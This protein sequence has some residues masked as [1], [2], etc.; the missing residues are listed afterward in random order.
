VPPL[1]VGAV[2]GRG[3]AMGRNASAV[4]ISACFWSILTTVPWTRGVGVQVPRCAVLVCLA[5]VSGE[6]P[7]QPLMSRIRAR[8]TSSTETRRERA[9][10]CPPCP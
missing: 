6:A 2:E 3:A 8:L 4:R 10:A 9:T 5:R 1:L 7:L